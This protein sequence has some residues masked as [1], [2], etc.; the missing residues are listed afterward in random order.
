VRSLPQSALIS[1]ARV[2]L[3]DVRAKDIQIYVTN[4]DAE[5]L[6]AKL[7]MAGTLATRAGQDSVFV[8]QTNVT[9]AKSN[10]CVQV[11]QT[12]SV[13]LDDQGG[14]THHLTISV[15]H[16]G[17]AGTEGN[18]DPWY[19][20]LSTYHAYLQ[21]YVPDS[22]QLQSADGFDQNQPMCPANCSADPYP[23]GELVCP[24]G[25]YNPGPYMSSI[26]G[27]NGDAAGVLDKLGGPTQTTSDV[28]GMTLW[29]GFV[30][31]PPDCTA[32]LTLAWYV[33][34]VVH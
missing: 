15:H 25:G 3:Q 31:I 18:C 27:P 8:V 26:I 14:A 5:G 4:P 6:L 7:G 28:P 34:G 17:G 1:I 13:T 2:M 32:N 30:V 21:I 24:P 11:T 22:A 29:G 20:E 9:G 12:D 16:I 33:P 23:G 19:G 10:P